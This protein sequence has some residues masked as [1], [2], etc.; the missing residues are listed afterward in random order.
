MLNKLYSFRRCPYAIRAR[1]AL[2]YSKIP[3][4]VIEVDLKNKPPEMREISPKN[5]VPILVVNPKKIIDEKQN[6]Y[7]DQITTPLIDETPL[8]F[9]STKKVLSL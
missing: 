3:F 9:L 5:T 4:S 8:Q 1:M 6:P 2:I 7:P